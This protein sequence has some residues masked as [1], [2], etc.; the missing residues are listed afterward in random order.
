MVL[1]TK[2]NKPLF[3]TKVQNSGLLEIKIDKEYYKNANY[4][5]VQIVAEDPRFHKVPGNQKKI[6]Y[7]EFDFM[8]VS[9]QNSIS[10]LKNG[11]NIH[12]R[13]H[14]GSMN[15]Y[16]LRVVNYY[17]MLVTLNVEGMGDSDLYVNPGKFSFP[18]SSDYYK[19]SIGMYDDELTLTKEDH[20]KNFGKIVK[21][22][23]WYTVG[24][25]TFS[26]CDYD[27]LALQNKYKVVKAYGGK[28]YSLT[29][30]LNEPV[31]FKFYAGSFAVDQ[32]E[33][34]LWSDSSNLEVFISKYSMDDDL[35]P[36]T[37]EIDNPLI[38]NIPTYKNHL[39][40]FRTSLLGRAL[41]KQVPVDNN[42]K[43]CYYLLSI[44]P[45]QSTH[46]KVN[47]FRWSNGSIMKLKNY[48]TIKEILNPGEGQEIQIHLDS[49]VRNLSLEFTV[50]KGG[51]NLDYFKYK[52]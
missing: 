10:E 18:T 5:I 19:K 23:V 22:E 2:K 35:N 46:S 14:K 26:T 15:F 28:L 39:Y 27:L 1:F 43:H 31:V 32:H 13:A 33:F 42:C 41:R 21:K 36:D 50:Y 6:F 34:M 49:Y 45:Y 29:T 4:P 47:F 16:H 7:D 9:I 3:A 30:K 12:K 8:G 40:T 11:I 52:S 25:Y 51:L 48:S 24:I 17:N 38:R 44:Y 20:E 37:D